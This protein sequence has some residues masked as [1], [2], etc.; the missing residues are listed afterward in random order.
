MWGSWVL[1]LATMP[2][3]NAAKVVQVSEAGLLA[4]LGLYQG[5]LYGT[6]LAEVVTH[7]LL[8]LDVGLS[9]EYTM[10]QPLN[11]S[12]QNDLA[13]VSGKKLFSRAKPIVS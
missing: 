3:M 8:L 1:L 11:Y 7:R 13:K 12:F 10:R 4:R 5:S 6:I 2:L 9:R